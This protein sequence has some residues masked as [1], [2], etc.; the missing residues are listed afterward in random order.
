MNPKRD[1][2]FRLKLAAGFLRE[3]EEDLQLSRWRS[4]VDNA[5][6]AVE[7][8]A[9]AVIAMRGPI[10]K[11]HRLKTALSKLLKDARLKS[12]NKEIVTLGEIADKLGFEEHIRTDYGDESQY[13]TPWELFDRESAEE[14]VSLARGAHDAAFGIVEKWP[15]KRKN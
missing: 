11:V 5:Q 12:L 14:A 3:A 1:A 13:R 8:A 2:E 9:K 4:C 10:P 15:R 7:N 6:M